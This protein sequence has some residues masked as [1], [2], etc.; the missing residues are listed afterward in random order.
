MGENQT[1]EYVNSVM[2]TPAWDTTAIFVVWDEWGG[3]YDHVPPPQVDNLSYGFRIPLLVI[4]PWTKYGESSDGGYIGHGF[5][6]HASFVRFV[7]N[8][9]QLP[10]LGAA[11][12]TAND[13][14]DFFDFAQVPKAPLV[15]EQ[16]TCQALTPH[17][18]HLVATE[19]P[20]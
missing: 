12:E 10:S 5:Y 16:R 13:F 4:S 17:Q 2:Q 15:L 3:F 20:D 6:T 8:H 14:S 1:V 18:K 9:W 7:E 11:D 19:D